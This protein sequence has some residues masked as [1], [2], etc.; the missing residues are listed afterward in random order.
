MSFKNIIL[1]FVF[2][3]LARGA[4]AQTPKAVT[5]DGDYKV[6][7]TIGDKVFTD[8]MTLLGKNS[9]IE[10]TD[11]QGDIAGLMTVPEMFTSS[12]RGSGYCADTKTICSM[13][14]TIEANENGEKYKVNYSMDLSGTNYRKA[15]SG[16]GIVFTGSAYLADGK[17]LGFYTA[18]K[19]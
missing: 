3:L 12:I 16:E 7:L 18:T 5:L 6:E 9:P 8:F 4:M 17:L 13:Y 2:L 1:P 11:F 10:I 15:V 19:Q 14:F